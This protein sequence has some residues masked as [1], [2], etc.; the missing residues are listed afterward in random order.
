[1]LTSW[2]SRFRLGCFVWHCLPGKNWVLTDIVLLSKDLC[3]NHDLRLRIT[4]EMPHQF[5]HDNIEDLM[6][7]L[8]RQK[9]SHRLV[10]WLSPCTVHVMPIINQRVVWIKTI[11]VSI[12]KFIR[13]QQ[14]SLVQNNIGLEVHH[15]L[16][17]VYLKIMMESSLKL[18]KFICLVAQEH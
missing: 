12:R 17:Q 4:P 11:S 10:S 13:D 18:R 6:Q 9:L 5:L 14:Q 8:K 1:M 16:N 3:L 2:C 15:E 7:A